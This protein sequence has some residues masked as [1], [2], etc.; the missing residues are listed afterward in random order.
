MLRVQVVNGAYNP[1]ADMPVDQ[2]R[3]YAPALFAGFP[4]K[5]VTVF[6]SIR[7]D[8]VDMAAQYWQSKAMR[9]RN[10]FLARCI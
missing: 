10:S 5:L 2:I 3:Q 9:A 1:A 4:V 6:V 7:F 8:A